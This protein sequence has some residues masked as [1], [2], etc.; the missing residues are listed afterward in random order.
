MKNKKSKWERF[1]PE[2][3]SA[4]REALWTALALAA[5]AVWSLTFLWRLGRERA[6]AEPESAAGRL[7]DLMGFDTMLGTA[8]AGFYLVALGM[9]C[10]AMWHYSRIRKSGVKDPRDAHGRAL[11]IP[12]I[13][14]AASLAATAAVY[15]IYRGVFIDYREHLEAVYRAAVGLEG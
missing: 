1:A 4:K 15:F 2:G 11:A 6:A 13:G 9:V 5:S 3:V 14:I 8:L 12:V 10:L 7:A